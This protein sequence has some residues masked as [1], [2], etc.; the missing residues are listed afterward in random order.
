MT[1]TI[2]WAGALALLAL[3]AA[4]PARAQAPALDEEILHA[5]VEVDGKILFPVVG[6]SA[7]PAERRAA[8]IARRIRVLARNRDVAPDALQRTDSEVGIA[9]AAGG[10]TVLT[11]TD[12]DA[13][14]VGLSRHEF[15]D[16]VVRRIGRAIQDFRDERRARNL[17]NASAWAA[18]ITAAA[19]AGAA[20]FLFLMRR[21]RRALG[22]RAEKPI[23]AVRIQSFELVRAESIRRWLR[24]LPRALAA[25]GLALIVLIWLRV[26]LDLFPWTRHVSRPLGSWLLD[27]LEKL[28]AAFVSKIPDLIFLAILF[29][30]LRAVLKLVR[31]FFEAVERG[32]IVFSSFEPEWAD[33]TY[34][35]VRLAVFVLGAVVAY[36]YIPGSSTDAFK[37]ISI[38]LGILASI[39]S[40]SAIANVVAGYSMIYRR[41]FRVGDRIRIGELVGDVSQI[42]LQVTHLRTAKN[43]EVI[44][45]N[46]TILRSEVINYSS[47]SRDTGLILHTRVRIGYD[48]PWRQVEAM[49]RTAADRTPGL[50]KDPLPFVLQ[51]EL[52]TSAVDYEVNAYSSDP[53]AMFR[54]LS[55]L[56]RNVL[57]IFNEYGVTIM[58]PSYEG[59][60]ERSKV[61]P[62]D[63]WYA[64]PASPEAGSQG[65][66]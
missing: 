9:I 27:P 29:L 28:G 14:A 22:R 62:K 16:A 56:H 6:T 41:A 54:T 60:P 47:V 42:R 33:P 45:P 26:V 38:F 15:A 18:G 58:T 32:Q 40:T 53:Q 52:G 1:R 63:R 59:D 46:S 64:P 50:L 25:L 36:P 66:P 19:V 7:F 10:L 3:I 30:I 24:T 57:D 34:K 17:L 13:R 61:V 31:R 12:T 2:R 4:L 37:G 21:L 55:A 51:R 11:V 49:L 48:T 23:E 39:G 43:E 8:E 20:L 65:K 35:L 5:P 44:V